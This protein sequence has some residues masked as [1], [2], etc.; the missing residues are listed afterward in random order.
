M[1]LIRIQFMIIAI[2]VIF[3]SCEKNIDAYENDPRIYFFER[4][5]DLN[6]SRITAK[7]FSFLTFPSIVV[8][9]TFLIKVKIMG[10][11]ASNDR[12]VRGEAI[13]NG[14]SA[15]AGQHYQFIDGKIAAGAV[16]GFLPVVL[17]RSAEIRTKTVQLNLR[18]A[19]TKDFKPGVTEDNFFSLSW[20]DSL[21]KPANWDTALFFFFGTYSEAKFRFVIDVT[22]LATFNLQASARVPLQPGELSNAA[23]LDMKQQ[24]KQ[25]LAAYNASHASPLSDENGQLI[26]FPL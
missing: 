6:A 19:E 3:T 17:L 26:S 8:R 13:A 1:K 14:T 16:T 18:I 4:A 11:P 22:G 21:I 15:V 20:N 9:D 2:S 24:L 10:L 12:V 7:S 23:M 25:A 5:E